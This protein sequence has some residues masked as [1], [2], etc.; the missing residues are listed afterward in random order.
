MIS[1]LH[2]FKNNTT[3]MKSNA[4]KFASIYLLFV[5]PYNLILQ[6]FSTKKIILQI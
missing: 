2:L 3:E 1:N 5:K 6:D 4:E